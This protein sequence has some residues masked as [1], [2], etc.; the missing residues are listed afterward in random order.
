LAYAAARRGGAAPA[1][2][3]AANEVAVEAFLN[4]RIAW[5]EIVAVVAT[6]MDQYND[7][8]LTTV[9]D[10]EREDATARRVAHDTLP[11]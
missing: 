5:R 3:S 7:A 4:G 2:L 6:T 9:E 11:L 8:V 1:W 10:L